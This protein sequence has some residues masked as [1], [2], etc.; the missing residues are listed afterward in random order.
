M[1][2]PRRVYRHMYHTGFTDACSAASIVLNLV[3]VTAT[4]TGISSTGDLLS[5][6]EAPTP[7]PGETVAVSAIVY[8]PLIPTFGLDNSQFGSA[9]RPNAFWAAGTST[10]VA[11]S[12][13]VAVAMGGASFL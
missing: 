9:G 12:V 5:P 6:F 4:P 13:T 1:L 10:V 2:T 3:E 11:I 7:T 8:Q